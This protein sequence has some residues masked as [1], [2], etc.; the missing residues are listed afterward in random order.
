MAG[1]VTAGIR[2]FAEM[3]DTSGFR[4]FQANIRDLRI[5]LLGFEQIAGSIEQ[6]GDAFL[7]LSS[8]AGGAVTSLAD[9]AIEL[10]DVMTR[11]STVGG[12]RLGATIDELRES[13]VRLSSTVP[14]SAAA[15]GEVGVEVARAGIAGRDAIEQFS[16]VSGQIAAVADDLS[17]DEAARALIRI[18]NNFGTATEDMAGNARFLGDALVRLAAEGVTTEGAITNVT[19]RSSQAARSL[20]LTQREALAVSA[21]VLNMG[22]SAEVAGTALAQTYSAL[23]ARTAQYA[24]AAGVSTTAVQDMIRSGRGLEAFQTVFGGIL[25]RVS[26]AQGKIDPIRLQEA[27]TGLGITGKRQR[28]VLVGLI[29]QYPELRRQLD[30][31]AG[32]AGDLQERFD[33]SSSS[34][35][36][37]LQTL[38]GAWQNLKAEFGQTLK[39]ILVPI[40]ELLTRLINFM[41]EL[42]SPVKFGIVAV[43]GLS[44][45]LFGA[46][47][48]TATAIAG[49][50][51]LVVAV[52]FLSR[53]FREARNTYLDFVRTL[54]AQSTI[55]QTVMMVQRGLITPMAGA[56]HTAGERRLVGAFDAGQMG[57]PS[58]ASILGRVRGALG[59]QAGKLDTL[60]LQAE[61]FMTSIPAALSVVLRFASVIAPIVAA[62]TA[63]IGLIA[64]TAAAFKD[65][66]NGVVDAFMSLADPV[67][68][69]VS[70]FGELLGM[71]GQV[72]LLS[73]M[74]ASW[75]FAFAPVASILNLVAGV[76]RVV[77]TALSTAV[78]A[79]KPALLDVAQ[80]ILRFIGGINVLLEK[81]QRFGA[82]LFGLQGGFSALSVFLAIVRGV[83]WAL[84]Q[85]LVVILDFLGFMLN[86]SLAVFGGVVE[87]IE[88]GLGP[89]F[90]DLLLIGSEIGFIFADLKA[91]FEP[92]IATFSELFGGLGAE[93]DLFGVIVQGVAAVVRVFVTLIL[94]PIRGLLFTVQL[95]VRG[96]RLLSRTIATVVAPVVSAINK[97]LAPFV[98]FWK[99][100]VS[101]QSAGESLSDWFKRKFEN[102]GTIVAG[103]FNEIIDWPRR[104]FDGLWQE[105]EALARAIGGQ[106]TGWLGIPFVPLSAG[107]ITTTTTPALVHPGEVV[108]PLDQ[109]PRLVS[110]FGPP[111]QPTA[112]LSGATAPPTGVNSPGSASTNTAPVSLSLTIPVQV[113]LEGVELG[114]AIVNV[115][116]DQIRQH[117]GSRGIRLAGIG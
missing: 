10:D 15:L 12:E 113:M 90:D 24:Q 59:P 31:S 73:I 45:A 7:R 49:F 88:R 21:A 4:A 47:G 60:L 102:F 65:E 70:L 110:R 100:M 8:V 56:R 54:Q 50:T 87:G 22:A 55:E 101:I 57:G 76:L 20:G 96:F 43:L 89:A 29:Q 80:P 79:I 33:V 25:A 36:K 95:I 40:L 32:A 5:N 27:F 91:A 114:R 108:A 103:V 109:L 66:I 3:G 44:A 62:V 75:R 1:V 17:A 37:V 14:L 86:L 85:P 28:D 23:A 106:I 64:F 93:F 6:L 112:A 117:F 13:F 82:A 58:A 67:R 97:I 16:L 81:F 41:V 26:D 30:L 51:A 77:S 92:L 98:M 84:V 68:S 42:P 2:F 111:P 83:V 116:E 63:G 11:I 99:T 74:L 52:G 35:K 78:E 38:A 94:L 39:P 107:G 18:S 69:A 53:S 46:V 34:L 105:F 48:A 104:F 115:T 9:A 19:V 61:A 71:T 72:S